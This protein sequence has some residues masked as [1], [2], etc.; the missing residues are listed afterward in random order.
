MSEH[1]EVEEVVQPIAPPGLI[2]TTREPKPKARKEK[3]KKKKRKKKKAEKVEVKAFYFACSSEEEP[4]IIPIK[5]SVLHGP[6]EDLFHRVHYHRYVDADASFNTI[7][8][9]RGLFLVIRSSD[10]TVKELHLESNQCIFNLS[11]GV[12]RVWRGNVLVVKE[13]LPDSSLFCDVNEGDL[14]VLRTFFKLDGQAPCKFS[15]N[16]LSQS[17]FLTSMIV[18][19]ITRH[20][21]MTGNP[22]QPTLPPSVPGFP[23]PEPSIGASTS[24][25]HTVDV[26]VF[27][28]TTPI[29]YLTPLS[30]SPHTGRPHRADYEALLGPD[31]IF[32]RVV[33]YAG[34]F[35]VGCRPSFG[36]EDEDEDSDNETPEDVNEAVM[37][38]TRRQGNWKRWPRANIMALKLKTEYE[39]LESFE[40]EGMDSKTPST[41]G[42]LSEASRVPKDATIF[43]VAPLVRYFQL[44][45]TMSGERIFA[46]FEG[47][48]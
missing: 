41:P 6:F 7:P 19:T 29:P 12:G 37:C 33:T 22:N 30:C 1:A 27:P 44:C 16:F 32:N 26:I 45:G 18:N 34:T 47:L 24:R 3:R 11:A 5:C 13:L 20:L 39:I 8:T 10:S 35:M 31:P 40:S 2:P 21:T 9:Y 48:G 17:L 25:K 15:I 46:Q 42:A 4:E 43:D 38:T 14:D 36:Y 28:A 23:F